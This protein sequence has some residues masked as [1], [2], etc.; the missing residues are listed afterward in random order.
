MYVKNK[1]YNMNYLYFIYIYIY[2]SIIF[3]QL[4]ECLITC[5]G[6][7]DRKVGA[8][9]VKCTYRINGSYTSL[10]LFAPSA[11]RYPALRGQRL[12]PLQHLMKDY[13]YGKRNP[14]R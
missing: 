8:G 12:P 13:E 10:P 7:T 4:I 1:L 9:Y 5:C 11:Q 6:V 2:M 3:L 14:K